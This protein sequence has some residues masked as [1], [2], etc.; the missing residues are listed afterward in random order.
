M[1]RFF[2]RRT[3]PCRLLLVRAS[4]GARPLCEELR[5]LSMRRYQRGD[6][7]ANL[8]KSFLPSCQMVGGAKATA[9]RCSAP[10]PFCVLLRFREQPQSFSVIVIGGISVKKML[11]ANSSR[12]HRKSAAR[13]YEK[14]ASNIFSYSLLLR[15]SHRRT[16]PKYNVGGQHELFG[17]HLYVLLYFGSRFD[18][19]GHT[20]AGHFGL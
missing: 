10:V 18:R 8:S 14:I 20:V 3:Y 1:F 9:R 15:V 11:A 7:A 5:Q 2:P 17:R 12:Q 4:L 19:Y 16:V 13:Q 6:S